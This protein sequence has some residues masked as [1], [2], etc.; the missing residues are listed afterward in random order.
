[1]A[2]IFPRHNHQGRAF[3]KP[4]SAASTWILDSLDTQGF[5]FCLRQKAAEAGECAKIEWH[6]QFVHAPFEC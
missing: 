1:M 6:A 2:D 3:G 4:D 5:G